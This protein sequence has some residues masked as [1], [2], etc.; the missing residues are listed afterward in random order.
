MERPS[1]IN[2]RSHH[3]ASRLPW[4]GLALS[5]QCATAWLF[6]QGLGNYVL[7]LPPPIIDLIPIHKKEV[8]PL[9]PPVPLRLKEMTIITV[10]EP[11]IKIDRNAESDGLKA[12]ATQQT[13]VNTAQTVFGVDRALAGI[14]GTHTVPPY[15]PVAQRLGVEGKVIL[16]LT[17]SPEGKVS[18]AQIVTSSGRADLDQAAQDWI[19]AHWA[20]KPAL[21]NG[22]PVVS[23]TLAAVTFSL[24]NQR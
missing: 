12:T 10:P 24:K 6:M 13:A 11:E 2:F 23:R 4:V 9:P 20:Y 21:E 8:P 5:L 1:H 3:F 19:L 18:S 7:R 15:P 22:E 17:V 14:V 16:R